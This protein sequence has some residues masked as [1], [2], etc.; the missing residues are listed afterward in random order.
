MAVYLE[1][2]PV[3]VV[4]TVNCSSTNYVLSLTILITSN[5]S[6]SRF[7]FHNFSPPIRKILAAPLIKHQT[8]LIP[9]D[10][11]RVC[12]STTFP[13]ISDIVGRKHAQKSHWV[14]DW[15]KLLVIFQQKENLNMTV[16]SFFQTFWLL[17]HW[18]AGWYET[19][20]RH[21]IRYINSGD[22]KGGPGWVIAPPDCR[23][24]PVWKWRF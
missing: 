20:F 23:L 10:D 14:I 13:R 4:S 8:R 12:L 11:M 3:F 6:F 21:S 18:Y 1:G 5:F 17:I 7:C 16:Y 15:L 9:K 22:S 19:V 2:P 24:A